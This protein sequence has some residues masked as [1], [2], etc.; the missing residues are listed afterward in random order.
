VTS[1]RRTRV[2]RQELLDHSR[3]A[4]D[5]EVRLRDHI[6]LLADE[7]PLATNRAVLF[8]SFGTISRW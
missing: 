4:A 1:I 3:R 2:E 8:C 5:G 6:L 7:H